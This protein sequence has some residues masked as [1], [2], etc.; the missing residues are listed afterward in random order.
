MI[1]NRTPKIKNGIELSLFSLSKTHS[2]DSNFLIKI[3]SLRKL[4]ESK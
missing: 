1:G 3:D 4:T 2:N